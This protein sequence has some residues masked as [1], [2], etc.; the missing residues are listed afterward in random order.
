MAAFK[1]AS[2]SES[3]AADQALA[4]AVI[5]VVVDGKTLVTLHSKL[6]NV[7]QVRTK[8]F[9]PSLDLKAYGGL[10]FRVKGDG[11]RYKCTIRT[12]TNWDGIGFT[13]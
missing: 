4:A 10:G 12:D 1:A 8:N 6:S 5:E 3:A 2:C 7:L 13:L 9:T 11:L